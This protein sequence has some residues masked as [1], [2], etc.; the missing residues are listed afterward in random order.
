MVKILHRI[1]KWGFSDKVLPYWCIL[2]YDSA[3]VI[4]S[5]VLVYYLQY[6]NNNLA[7]NIGRFALGIG[8]CLVVY[9]L[10]FFAFHTFNGVLRYSSFID[11]HRVAYSTFVASVVV[12]ALHQ[13]QV[14]WGLTP[15]LLIPRFVSG[16]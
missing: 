12:C 15:Y 7:E 11:L 10:T 2:A 1:C 4:I 5:G 13:V 16:L 6:G 8:I 9:I 14:H 3:S